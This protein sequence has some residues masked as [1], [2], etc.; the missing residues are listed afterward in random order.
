MTNKET[1]TR[2]DEKG[3]MPEAS[4]REVGGGC[5]SFLVLLINHLSQFAGVSPRMTDLL[6]SMLILLALWPGPAALRPKGMFAE[7]AFWAQ[8][9]S[10]P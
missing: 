3:K 5:I 9:F 6:L 4:G 10:T 7:A 8:N 1:E 2:R